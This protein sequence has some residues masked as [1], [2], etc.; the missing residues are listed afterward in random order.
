MQ[1]IDVIEGLLHPLG[2]VKIL[3][4]SGIRICVFVYFLGYVF[5]SPL[6]MILSSVFLF[7]YGFLGLFMFSWQGVNLFAQAGHIMMSISAGYTL[8]LIIR[9]RTYRTLISGVAVGVLVMLGFEIFL[10]EPWINANPET[11]KALFNGELTP[12]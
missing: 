10:H 2:Y 4:G 11:F 8:F 9:E 3:A 5:K 12:W 1:R 6:T 7:R